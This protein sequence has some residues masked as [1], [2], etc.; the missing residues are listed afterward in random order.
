[1]THP[2]FHFALS[3]I[4]L[5][6]LQVLWLSCYCSCSSLLQCHAW[7]LIFLNLLQ[8]LMVIMFFMFELTSMSCSKSYLFE[9]VTSVNSCQYFLMFK[10][11]SM[12][13]TKPHLL[14]FA[15]SINGCHVF[16]F[17]S[18]SFQ[19]HFHLRCLVLWYCLM[20]S[21]SFLF[22]FYSHSSWCYSIHHVDVAPKT[23]GIDVCLLIIL[24]FMLLFQVQLLLHLLHSQSWY[25]FCY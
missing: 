16:K 14:E 21:Q 23:L 17:T 1:V 18:M 3:I 7:S 5:N 2:L 22:K 11:T 8:V 4:S 15:I 25:F 9:F 19:Q 10:F 6:L 13:C 24:P 12:S 20:F